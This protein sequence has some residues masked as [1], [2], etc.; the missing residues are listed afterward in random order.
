ME[1]SLG[2]LAYVEKQLL[3]IMKLNRDTPSTLTYKIAE[4][5][6]EELKGFRKGQETHKEKSRG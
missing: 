1:I 6:Y 2:D 3:T 5:T 4:A